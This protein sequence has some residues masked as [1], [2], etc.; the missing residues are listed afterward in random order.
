MCI[1]DRLSYDDGE[2]WDFD[3]DRIIIDYANQGPS[4]GGYGNTVQ[5]KDDSLVSTY[6]FR[7]DDGKTHV[8]AVKWKIPR[9]RMLNP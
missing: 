4:G 1:R 6:S 3:H 7:G 2:T 9:S 8:E 5:L